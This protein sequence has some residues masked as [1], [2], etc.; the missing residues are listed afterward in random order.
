[1]GGSKDL[2][3]ENQPRFQNAI[4]M[5]SAK[6]DPYVFHVVRHMVDRLTRMGSHDEAT[7]IHELWEKR[8]KSFLP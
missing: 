4:V 6:K 2:V 5:A 3:Q 1:M 8:S 7:W